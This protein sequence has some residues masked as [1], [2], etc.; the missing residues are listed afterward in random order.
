M[1]SPLNDDFIRLSLFKILN[2]SLKRSD[3]NKGSGLVLSDVDPHHP[4]LLSSSTQL[5]SSIAADLIMESLDLIISG[6]KLADSLFEQGSPITCLLYLVDCK[7]YKFLFYI[8]FSS[9]TIYWSC[10]V[11]GYKRI[12]EYENTK[13]CSAPPVKDF[14]NEIKIH[15]CSAFALLLESNQLRKWKIISKFFFVL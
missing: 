15:L 4:L 5:G 9:V 6:N 1:E 14:L 3:S 10:V 11:I 2:V 8:Q 12:E 7:F 13:R